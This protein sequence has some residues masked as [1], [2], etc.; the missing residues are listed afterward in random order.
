VPVID[1][2]RHPTQPIRGVTDTAHPRYAQVL[3]QLRDATRTIARSNMTIRDYREARR[4]LASLEGGEHG[5]SFEPRD[6]RMHRKVLQ[7]FREFTQKLKRSA[8]PRVREAC[9]RPLLALWKERCGRGRPDDRT[10]VFVVSNFQS[11]WE[12]S[13]RDEIAEYLTIVTLV[14]A[15]ENAV[16]RLVAAPAWFHELL[17]SSWRRKDSS[18]YAF[19]TDVPDGA[20]V[21]GPG[22]NV[23]PND[24]E[25]TGAIAALWSD[26]PADEY[27]SVES[28]ID[29][30][31][32]L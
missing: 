6:P 31:R 7:A 19:A 4:F 11:Y 27:F 1:A 30:A 15:G 3:A 29:A 23:F 16:H 20:P 8:E 26:D 22:G 21:L 25:E 2:N 28:V 18:W 32:L 13:V 14:S 10:C 24:A 5:E 17:V 12:P 9:E